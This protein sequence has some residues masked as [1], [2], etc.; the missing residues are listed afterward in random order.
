MKYI[1][2][3]IICCCVL[4]VLG[5]QKTVNG[6][7][8]DQN[9][10]LPGATV[11]QKDVPNNGTSTAQDGTFRLTLQGSGSTLVVTYIGY[12]SRE[13]KVP[14]SGSLD[15]ALQP[16]ARGM[17]EVVIVGF[18]TQ[19]KITNTG[20]ISSISGDKIRQSPSASVQNALMGRL[21][22]FISQQRSGQPGSDG[23]IFNIRGVS[24]FNGSQ[25]LI[26][27]DDVEYAGVISDIDADQIESLTILKDAA[28]TAV[29]GIKG[30]NGVVVITTRRGKLGRP[31]IT[32]RTETGLQA[33]VYPL[34]FLDSYETAVLRNQALAND[35][36]PVQ[37]TDEDLDHFKNGTDPYGHPNINWAKELL[38]RT[39]VQQRNNLNISG[40][41]DRVKYFASLGYISQNGIIKDFSNAESDVNTNF[42]YKRYNFRSN[43][44]VQATKSLS[45]SLD[46]TGKFGEQNIPN[47]MGRTGNVFFELSDYSFLPAY[48]YPIYNP[49]GSF[50]GNRSS[51]LA[52]GSSNIIGRLS[53]LGY[54]R[55]FSNEMILNL[56][57]D[58]DLDVLTPGLS[59]RALVGYTNTNAYSRDLTRSN[60]PSY[61]YNSADESYTPYEPDLYRTPPF[62]LSYS[63]GSMRKRINLQASVNYD[64]TFSKAHHIYALA[65]MNQYTFT[66]GASEPE[67]FRGYS[68]R[69][70]YDYRQKYLLEFNGAYNG[71][72][73]FK[74]SER[75]GFFPAVSAGW[76][77][78][79]EPFFK[80][81]LPFINLFKIRGSIGIVGSDQ[82][83][84]GGRYIY[85]QIYARGGVYSIG[86]VHR[87]LEGIREGTLANLD[88]TWEKERS[89]NVGIDVNMFKGKL[90]LVA[91]YF[92]RYRYDILLNRR[93]V[94]EYSG[95]AVPPVNMGRM[96]NRG[97]EFD[98]TW[99]DRIGEV[100]Y[101]V[102]GNMTVTKN[103]VLEID[104]PSPAFPWLAETGGTYGR[105][106]G[107]VYE[108]FYSESD[109]ADTKVPKPGIAV[110][111]G[112]LKYKD[113]NGD[114]NIDINDQM[115]LPYANVPA[116][117]YGLNLGVNYKGLS[118]GVSLQAATQFTFRYTGIQVIPFANNLRE[119][120]KDTW[121]PENTNPA[122][123]RLSPDWKSTIND[124]WNSVSDF[125]NRRGDYLRLRNAEIGYTFPKKWFSGIGINNARIYANGYN[126]FT[127]M[128]VDE[129]IYD[130]DP[131]SPTATQEMT[132]P[133]QKI[134]N[135]GLQVSF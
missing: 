84:S 39:P 20:A 29:Y 34:E 53:M 86:E 126:L 83:S 131:E 11:Y 35:G 15:V 112:D 113:L 24:S 28:S 10:P 13:V 109:I 122:L 118:I 71:T 74:A 47:S 57:A 107:Y 119:I 55:D 64:R 65:L 97:M 9:G 59:I 1:F 30:A 37:W 117:V 82:I 41:T 22:G 69:A 26:I 67:N 40:G 104:E 92:D 12:L 49:D 110:K 100:G 63:A 19:K 43:I 72:D 8:T 23:A 3:T 17:E 78:S 76:N 90:K 111:P 115:L 7:V 120:H 68:F 2:I 129:N 58:Q 42:Y 96:S 125:W 80:N 133:Q 50:G 38:R 88:V 25:P 48:A 127:W 54:N 52:P 102:N 5:Q 124:P 44:D 103:K 62:S 108:G 75:Y 21:P 18:G 105:T 135:F 16:D 77:M 116:M 33:P 36:L 130:L 93:S 14:A 51:M 85:E 89:M 31:A 91:D 70:G 45:L 66:A 87:A 114:G 6:K 95:V 134:Y 32:F 60:F 123:P 81:A 46:V 56:K 132:Y 4:N 73:R 79:E 98:L 101:T 27:V 61:I 128:L 99:S 94:P 121:T 106:R